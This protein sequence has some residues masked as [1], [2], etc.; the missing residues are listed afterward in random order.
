MTSTNLLLR[1][2]RSPIGGF[3]V[4]WCMRVY[5]WVVVIQF[6]YIMRYVSFIIEIYGLYLGVF[7]LHSKWGWHVIFIC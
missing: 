5:V 3:G 4:V 6:L 1:I 2:L 7:V